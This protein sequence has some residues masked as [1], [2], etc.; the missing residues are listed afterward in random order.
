A[1]SLSIS[2]CIARVIVTP[3]LLIGNEALEHTLVECKMYAIMEKLLWAGTPPERR[4][5]M[6]STKQVSER[7]G[8]SLALVYQWI[9]SGMLRHYGLGRGKQGAIRVAEQDLAEFLESRKRGAQPAK[10]APSPKRH[11][12]LAHLSMP[13]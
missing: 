6:L 10:P 8:V 12:K 7:L 9:T 11:V 1:T 3:G 13:S 5:E 2:P 4:R